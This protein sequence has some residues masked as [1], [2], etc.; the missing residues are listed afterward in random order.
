MVDHIPGLT[1]FLRQPEGNCPYPEWQMNK[2]LTER[3]L[4]LKELFLKMAM[5]VSGS[6]M[7][8]RSL[9]HF[10]KVEEKCEKC[11]TV[12]SCTCYSTL[13]TIDKHLVELGVL[14]F[15]C[16][17]AKRIKRDSE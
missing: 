14:C 9:Y 10:G 17:K 4:N 6:E 16:T 15:A 7:T 13:N 1:D 5:S 11:Q 3:V 12:I 2:E 8:V